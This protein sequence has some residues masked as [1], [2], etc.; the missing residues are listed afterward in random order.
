[1][2]GLAFAYPVFANSGR[3]AGKPGFLLVAGGSAVQS[4]CDTES[5]VGGGFR[6]DFQVGQDILHQRLAVQV[7][8]ESLAPAAVVDDLAHVLAHCAGR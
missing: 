7:F 5:Q 2:T 6:L 4:A 8:A 1:M 3:D